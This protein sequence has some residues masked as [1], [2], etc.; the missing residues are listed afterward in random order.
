MYWK[1]D[2]NEYLGL[3]RSKHNTQT[4]SIEP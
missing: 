4:P 2:S 1:P 3:A